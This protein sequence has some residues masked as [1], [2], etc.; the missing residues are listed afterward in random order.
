MARTSAYRGQVFLGTI[1]GADRGDSARSPTFPLPHSNL[2]PLASTS[3]EMSRRLQKAT[4][5]A[6]NRTNHVDPHQAVTRFND[7]TRSSG[8]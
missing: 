8:S 4:K 5:S 7:A 6:E 2:L 1:Q 3:I